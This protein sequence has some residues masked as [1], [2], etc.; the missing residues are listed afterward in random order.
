MKSDAR[1]TTPIHAL[2]L[3]AL[4]PWPIKPVELSSLVSHSEVP[5]F[6]VYAA[7]ARLW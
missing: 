7:A 1:A 3:W 6:S 4:S 2:E 5:Q